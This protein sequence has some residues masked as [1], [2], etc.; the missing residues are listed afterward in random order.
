MPK[1]ASKSAEARDKAVNRFLLT[2]L[3]RH[4]TCQNS[5]WASSLQNW[6]D[7]LSFKPYS[8]WCFIKKALA[9]LIYLPYYYISPK[10]TGLFPE[11]N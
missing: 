6:G 1:A 4:P 8:L 2:A 3:R 5:S 11:Y 7:K 10:P 9:D